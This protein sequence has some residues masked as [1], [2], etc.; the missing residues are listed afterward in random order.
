MKQSIQEQK[1]THKLYYIDILISKIKL[2]PSTLGPTSQTKAFGAAYLRIK[3]YIWANTL[4]HI[5]QEENLNWTTH[6][7]HQGKY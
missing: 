1:C 4:H 7:I 3:T 2:L 6:H 5:N